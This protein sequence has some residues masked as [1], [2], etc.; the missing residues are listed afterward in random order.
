MRILFI[1]N[2]CILSVWYSPQSIGQQADSTAKI[3]SVSGSIGI[4]NNGFSIIPTFSLNSPATIINLAIRRN[5]LSFEPDFRLVPSLNKGGLLF[6][7]R[8]YPVTNKK[9]RL[10]LGAHPALSLVRKNV[11]LNGNEQEITEMLRFVAGEIVPSY[12]ISSKLSI[13]AV[14]LHGTG[15]QNHGPQNTDVLFLNSVISGIKLGGPISLNLVP[16]VYFLNT[17][18]HVGKYY[19]ATAAL[20]HKKLP[21]TLQYTFNK[22]ISSDVPGNKDFMWNVMLAYNFRNTYIKRK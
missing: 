22:T 10:R 12:Q 1:V 7:L 6:W 4:T 19:T 21:Y 20:A 8:Y 16:M 17:D 18:G 9:F 15:L 3:T 2:L 11:I 14:Y 5:K 13:G